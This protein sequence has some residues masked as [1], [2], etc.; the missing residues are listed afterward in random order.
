[1]ERMPFIESL[2]AFNE[3]VL[4]NG[5]IIPEKLYTMVELKQKLFFNKIFIEN[6]EEVFQRHNCET[7]IDRYVEDLNLYISNISMI[8]RKMKLFDPSIQIRHYGIA[9]VQKDQLIST[10]YS[11][12]YKL[13]NGEIYYISKLD[14]GEVMIS[15]MKS[16]PNNACQKSDECVIGYLNETY[17][18]DSTIAI[19]PV[20]SSHDS[21][22]VT[23]IE[24]NGRSGSIKSI[25][26]II[27]PEALVLSNPFIYTDDIKSAIERMI[28]P[29]PIK[30]EQ[31]FENITFEDIFDNDILIEYPTTSFD[32]YLNLLSSASTNKDMKAIYLSLYRIGKDPVIYSILRDAVNNGIEVYVNIELCASGESINM[33]WAE[34]MRDAGINV[35]TYASGV[36]K[37]HSK[38]TLFKFKHGKAISQIG[39]G[40]YHTQTTSQYTD[41]SLITSDKDIC[42]Q[43]MNV[44]HIF[45][46]RVDK[47]FFN[48]NLLVTRYNARSELIKLIRRE[49]KLGEN[50]YIT[51]KCNALDDKEIA[52]HLDKAAANNCQIDLIVRGVCTWVP[53]QIG[54]NVRIKSIVWDK[55]EHSRVYCFGSFNPTMYIGSLDLVTNKIDN[56]IETLVRIL[57]PDILDDLCDYLNHYI[58]NA[59]NSWVLLRSGE[60]RKE[61]I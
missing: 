8:L 44:F 35:T 47:V 25:I 4:Y 16:Y 17:Q 40:N 60:Y 55:L 53:D 31:K 33:V 59:S 54:N 48:S 10:R 29:T 61:E 30:I 27:A 34:E 58:T 51:F 57:D 24:F 19:R 36:L 50:G 45:E 52:M 13:L 41:L 38:L 39:T 3:R 20:V 46:D 43:V 37:V 42:R 56:R 9:D 22:K 6:M 28:P 26:D 49:A 5:N 21:S 7:I 12:N 2:I 32:V 11:K 23:K 15:Q 1:M 18:T 14:D